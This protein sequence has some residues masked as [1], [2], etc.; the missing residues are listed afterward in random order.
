MS[1]AI[2]RE[3]FDELKN[4]LGVYLQQGR[5]ILDSDW[6]ESQDLAIASDRR[7]RSEALGEGSPNRGFAIE[8]LSLATGIEALAGNSL[9]FFM[10]FPGTLLDDFETADGWKLSSPLGSIR[11]SGD[12][13]YEGNGFLR[14]SG[15]PGT[16]Q[17]TR[18]LP[19]DVDLSA[20]EFVTFRYRLNQ[21]GR[22]V[23]KFFVEDRNGNR[24]V[25]LI[26][27][28]A[29]AKDFWLTGFAGPL[30]LQLRILTGSMQ[31][32]STSQTYFHRL[33][34]VGGTQPV[35]ATLAAGALPGGLTLT[36]SA[37]TASGPG[38]VGFGN[39]SPTATGDF[40]FTVKLTDA[41]GK[42]ATRSLS[43][44]V[45]LNP[46][47]DV[48]VPDSI[49]K[50]PGFSLPELPPGVPADLKRIQRYGFEI[51]QDSANPLIWDFDSLRLGSNALYEQMAANNFAIRGSALSQFRNVFNLEGFLFASLSPAFN[52]VE[53]FSFASSLAEPG[54][55][56]AGRM[57]VAG[58]PC[59]QI[60]DTLYSSQADPNDPPL[61]PPP[62]GVIRKDLVY[63]D[64]WQEP[65]TYVED[66]EIREVALGGPD[67][68]TRLRTRSRV[69]VSQGS[70]NQPGLLPAGGIGKGTLSSEGS[71]TGAANR[72]YRVE[73]DTPG[74]IN[75]ATFRWSD[76]NASTIQRVIQSVPPGST[77]VI[78]EDAAMLRPGDQIL[79]S[80]DSG[81][82]QHV[83]ASVSG[84]AVA[85]VNPTGSQLGSLPANGRI[86]NFTTFAVADHPKIQRWNELKVPVK[87]DP[88]D[89]TVSA[90]IPLNDGVQVRF[91][92][93]AMAA[94]DYWN[95]R[96]RFLAGDE[97]SGLDPDSRI[98]RLRFKRPRGVMHYYAPLALMSRNGSNI[99]PA[100]IVDIQDRRKRTGN[101]HASAGSFH[102]TLQPAPLG[103]ALLLF[104][105]TVNWAGGVPISPGSADSRFLI[106][107]SGDMGI[108][109]GALSD[110]SIEIRAGLYSDAMTDPRTDPA[111]GRIREQR[112]LIPLSGRPVD[113]LV[114]LTHLFFDPVDP[115]L[116][117]VPTLAPTSVQIFAMVNFPAGFCRLANIEVT[118][119]EMKKGF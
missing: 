84:N 11:I 7:L 69:R 25:W 111:R 3:G 21:P 26:H 85:L 5:V 102:S 40:A 101:S 108:P 96:T 71:Y 78:V 119:I 68:S 87:A 14:V 34:Y 112:A 77:R 57:Y 117:I 17:L 67:T 58:L 100:Q 99:K 114:P 51:Y 10:N 38:Q 104:P 44:K 39:S 50:L 43:L 49:E 2:S 27:D 94:G 109:S 86:T 54:I 65:V 19:R 81:S 36:V 18:T 72:L 116:M 70:G 74:D 106:Y 4:Y 31:R 61:T 41:T 118:V 52:P 103:G 42:T 98:E 92:G 16:V 73:I 12:Q 22:G 32:G 107:W 29:I 75:T 59:T 55:E 23:L 35:T 79:L 20:S 97:L 28:P 48:V 89:A 46:Q 113:V 33:T 82:E 115:D 66:P 8:S 1:R 64:V 45:L 110:S 37:P 80:K 83:I 47:A 6:N 13:P 95:F 24:S 63:L 15:H 62:S 93:R 53:A 9:P 56:N 90:T 91:G 60:E 76:D 30:D 105:N 88:Q